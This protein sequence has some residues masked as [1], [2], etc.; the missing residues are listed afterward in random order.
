[1]V[2]R[3]KEVPGYWEVLGWVL[4]GTF[5]REEQCEASREAPA[6]VGILIL[7]PAKLKPQIC[8]AVVQ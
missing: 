5:S 7:L 2:Q 3:Y 1:M 6:I 8:T 4:R